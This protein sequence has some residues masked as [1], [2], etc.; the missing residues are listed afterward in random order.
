MTTEPNVRQAVPFLWVH[1]MRRSLAF[2][3]D[4]LGCN[5]SKQWLDDGKVRWCWLELG[6]AAIMLQEFWTKGRHRNLPSGAVGLGVAINFMCAD[7]VRLWREAA[8][9]GLAVTRPTVGNGLWVTAILDPDGYQLFFE[10][11]ADAPDGSV[12]EDHR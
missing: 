3:V 6:G 1:D 2:Y 10:S 12:F 8:S 11:P 9:R 5:I 4:G 7:A